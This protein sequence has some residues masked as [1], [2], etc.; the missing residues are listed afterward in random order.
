MVRQEVLG[1]IF[2]VCAGAIW[3][4]EAVLGKL[5]LPSVTVVQVAATEAFFATVTVVGYSLVRRVDLRLDRAALRQVSVVGVLGT[6]VA[7]LL[8]F[9]GLSQT[10]AINASL[11]AHLQPL[12]VAVLGFHC[13]GERLGRRD[14]AAGTVIVAAAIFITSRTVDNLAQFQIG[15][16]GDAMVLLA[17]VCWALVAIPGKRLARRVS[18][19]AI[20]CYRFLIASAVFVP[21][22][23][24]LDL[25]AVPSPL[26]VVLGALIGVGYICYYEGL[27]RIEASH[28]ALTELA[29]PLFTAFFAW[30]VLGE[31]MTPLQGLGVVLLVGGLY[32]LSTQ[33]NRAR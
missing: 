21:V 4:F 14:L 28:V 19:A 10:Y 18:S 16:L 27:R 24:A 33:Q 9:S 12:V 7:P 3:A 20:V 23:L 22:L 30:R 11:I 26:Q 8:Y 29:S 1:I 17:T 6:V 13:L 5:L 31:V 32:L 2:G 15:G 25:F